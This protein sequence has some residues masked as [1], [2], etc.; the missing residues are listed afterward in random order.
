MT[1]LA[2]IGYPLA[3]SVSP[4]MYNAAF[5][6]MG[7]DATYEAWPIPPEE[8][9]EAIRS[10]RDEGMLGMNV[11]VPHKEA[12]LSLVD[13]LEPV[14]AAIGAVN[15]IVKQDSRLIGHNTD[16]YGFI[17]SL[18]EAGCEP[19]GRTALLLGAGGSARAVAFALVEAGATRVSIASRTRERADQLA[20]S[21][22]QYAGGSHIRSLGWLDSDFV[23][24]CNDAELIVN[25]TPVGMKHSAQE[26]DSPL[27][28]ELLR[29]DLWVYDLVY[30]PRQ[31]VLLAEAKRAGA[32]PIG[33]LE[34]LVYQAAESVRLWTG[35]EAPVNI[36]L[37]AAENA[38]S[39]VS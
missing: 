2:L 33:G 21:L 22:R 26:N 7:I 23:D 18:R 8:V 24:A 39:E 35:R 16:R 9:A 27:P 1:R 30:N 15:C 19:Q 5:P 6:A 34:M 14:A 25:C 38:L 36:M 37:Q 13:E 12:V 20:E 10:L 17:R 4:A 28:A 32:K 31:T 29:T 3:H 11:T